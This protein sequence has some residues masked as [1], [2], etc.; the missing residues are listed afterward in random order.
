MKERQ[1]APYGVQ[2]YH[3]DWVEVLVVCVGKREGEIDREK[4]LILCSNVNVHCSQCVSLPLQPH[5]VAADR[6][7]FYFAPFYVDIGAS[8]GARHS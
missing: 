4:T 7:N 5:H 1:L 6:K 8:C 3:V 2:K